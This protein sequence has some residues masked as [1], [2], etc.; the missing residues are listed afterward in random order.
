MARSPPAISS[1]MQKNKIKKNH[2]FVPCFLITSGE[3]LNG[4]EIILIFQNRMHVTT[5]R[6][7]MRTCIPYIYTSVRA[8]ILYA[9]RYGSV[10]AGPCR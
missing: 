8:R 6:S 2:R 4:G 10:P 9:F 3:H 7:Q 5:D 1:T